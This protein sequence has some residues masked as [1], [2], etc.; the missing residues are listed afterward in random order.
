[1][2]LDR[3]RGDKRRTTREQVVACEPII[4]GGESQMVDADRARRLWAA[5]DQL[6]ETLRLTMVLAALEGHSIREVASLTDAPE[7]T[8]KFRVF[9]GKRRLREL[10]S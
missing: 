6:P 5:I 4:G 2:A 3:R 10:L 1:L 9:E 7:G 8:V